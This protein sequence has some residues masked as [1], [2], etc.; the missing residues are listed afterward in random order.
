MTT[1]DLNV[2]LPEQNCA[3]SLGLTGNYFTPGPL[4]HCSDSEKNV[5][6]N[7]PN[8]K[9]IMPVIFGT[10]TKY[11]RPYLST[12]YEHSS[13]GREEKIFFFNTCTGFYYD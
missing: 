5:M 7:E 3:F 11:S 12:L 8:M 10:H 1:V 13:A 4:S 6:L 9:I 2:I